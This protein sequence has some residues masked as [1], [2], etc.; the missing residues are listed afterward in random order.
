MIEILNRWWLWFTNPTPVPG[1][2][3]DLLG[4]GTVRIVE[5]DVFPVFRL[6]WLDYEC[7]RCLHRRVSIGC[8]LSLAELIVPETQQEESNEP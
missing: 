7:N 1:Q 6:G 5:V 8:F 2:H 3:W 4:V